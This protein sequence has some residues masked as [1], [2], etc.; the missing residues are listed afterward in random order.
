MEEG[1]VSYSL[2]QSWGS[3]GRLLQCSSVLGKRGQ[4]DT[5]FFSPEEERI[6]TVFF[7]LGE[8]GEDSY[9]LLQSCGRGGS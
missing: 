3:G 8:E 4:N 1:E 7:S 9:S 6:V 5:V 2:L